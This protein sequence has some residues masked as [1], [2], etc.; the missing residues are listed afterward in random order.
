MS[1]AELRKVIIS[2]L[3]DADESLLSQVKSN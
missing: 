2:R 3:Q 1:I